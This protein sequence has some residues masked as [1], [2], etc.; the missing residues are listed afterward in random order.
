[1][2]ILRLTVLHSAVLQVIKKLQNKLN[3][4]IAVV[5]K[6]NTYIVIN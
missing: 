4:E 6:K 2:M 3:V 1:M 5:R